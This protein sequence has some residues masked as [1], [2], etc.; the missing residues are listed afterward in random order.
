MN[1]PQTYQGI[2]HEGRIQ[3]S[4]SANLPEGSHVYVIVTNQELM[5]SEHVAQRK[6]TRWLVEWVGN[7]LIAQKGRLV[8]RDSRVV[9]RFGAFV[10]AQ[11]HQ[12]RG[13]IG[14]VDVDIQSGEVLADT[15]LATEMIADGEVFIRSLLST[16][17]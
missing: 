2:V 16:K 17:G 4:D 1:A 6:A 8:E 13:P 7:M 3:L 11:G 10:T 15:Q 9:W 12:P 14:Y 5:I